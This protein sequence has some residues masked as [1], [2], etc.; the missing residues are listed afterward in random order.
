MAEILPGDPAVF[1]VLANDVTGDTVDPATVQIVGT[2]NPGDPLVVPGQGTWTVDPATGVITFT[3]QAGFVLDPD[4]ISYVVSDAHGNVSAPAE[5]SADYLPEIPTVE[6]EAPPV[7][8]AAEEPEEGES[9]LTVEPIVRETAD[10]SA[11]LY[12]ITPLDVDFPIL[13]AVNNLMDL[14][15]VQA[16]PTQSVAFFAGLAA[17]YPITMAVENVTASTLFGELNNVQR[18]AFDSLR[19]VGDLTD[20]TLTG[21]LL[22][23]RK[24]FLFLFLEATGPDQ[25]STDLASNI[26]VGGTEKGGVPV[27]AH[28]SAEGVQSIEGTALTELYAQ[29]GVASFYLE[30]LDHT[31]VV[32]DVDP[33]ADVAG[34]FTINGFAQDA[35]FDEQVAEI[36]DT[37]SREMA[38]LAASLQVL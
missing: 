4:P 27:L 7:P 22:V 15:G 9:E 26:W 13:G 35:L 5:L 3:P 29:D 21:Y 30:T 6:P 20:G 33:A 24:R 17:E 38:D 32:I 12:S 1:D 16:L 19:G 37:R 36:V 2:A 25:N 10:N 23:G 34:M 31:G 18:D 11:P 28:V 8:E 14:S